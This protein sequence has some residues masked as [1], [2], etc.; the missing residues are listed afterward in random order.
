MSENPIG[1]STSWNSKWAAACHCCLAVV[2]T[3]W[4][5][6]LPLGGGVRGLRRGIVPEPF[7]ASDGGGVNALSPPQGG[8][9]MPG[10][11]LD[12]W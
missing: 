2:G 7:F 5:R 4:E 8:V 9:N 1:H 6:V 11:R 10:Q 12:I 3:E